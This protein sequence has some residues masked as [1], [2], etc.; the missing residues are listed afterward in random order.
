MLRFRADEF[1]DAWFATVSLLVFC[2]LFV[3]EK[4]FLRA[5]VQN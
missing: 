3:L 2:T 4:R 1:V 5:D